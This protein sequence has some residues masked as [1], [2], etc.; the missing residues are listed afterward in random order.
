MVNNLQYKVDEQDKVL[1]VSQTLNKDSRNQRLVWEVFSGLGRTSKYLSQME[2][3]KV[4]SFSLQTGWDFGKPS[5]R[6]AFL[7]KLRHDEP[8]DILLSPMC[9]L[10]S[11]LQELNCAQSEDYKTKLVADRKLNHD[12]ILTMCS[13]AYL[14][15]QRHG[16]H[17]TPGTSLA[18]PCM[19]HPCIP[20]VGGG[21][22]RCLCGPM[23]VWLDLARQAWPGWTSE[24]TDLFPNN[25]V[26]HEKRS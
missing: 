19:V 16:R 11:P 21:Q 22:L 5:H 6:R 15:Q 3:V 13:V 25:E 24:E 4:V 20:E 26:Q 17:A 1:S 18:Q 10:W 8:D 12:T 14:E 9:R 23:P 2:N 7:A